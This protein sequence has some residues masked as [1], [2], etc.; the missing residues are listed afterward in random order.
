MSGFDGFAERT[1]IVTIG[2]GPEGRAAPAANNPAW[3]ENIPDEPSLRLGPEPAT[4]SR[5]GARAGFIYRSRPGV[6]VA[7]ACERL[8]LPDD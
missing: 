7:I 4:Q 5:I 1:G 3:R 6:V 2:D 8:G